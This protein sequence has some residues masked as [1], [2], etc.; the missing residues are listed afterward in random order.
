MDVA[1]Q[2]VIIV[3]GLGVALVASDVAV[4]YARSLAVAL[5]APAFVVGV[6]LVGVGTDLPEIANSIAA[7]LQDEGDV[8]VANASGS[9]L[10]QDTLVLGIA[11]FF[12]VGAIL[13]LRRQIGVV[14]GL[15]VGGLGLTALTVSDGRLSRLDGIVL[16]LFWVG[17]TVVIVRLLG[18]SHVHDEPPP[19][20]VES[21]WGRAGVVLGS[22]ILVGVGA[23]VA[24]RALVDLA[25]RIGVPEFILAF[26]GTSIGTSA[27]EIVVVLTAISRGVPAIALG[28]ALG[29]S[30]ADSSLS[31]GTGP[32]FAPADVTAQLGVVGA[33]YTLA[34]VAVMALL[35]GLRRMHDRRSGSVLIAVYL[36]SY[37]VIIAAD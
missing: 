15:T 30:L 34:A 2:I 17:A 16:V 22:L 13:I 7:H 18:G 23:T 32:I 14:A 24:V 19:V 20:R 26:F 33:L 8:N 11:P 27:P 28:D 3:V 31:V 25:E 10:T 4:S 21:T 35:L 29:S 5:G 37:V 6:V 1:V 36:L 12:A 9:A